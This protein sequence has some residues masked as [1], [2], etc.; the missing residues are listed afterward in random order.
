[1]NEHIS[2]DVNGGVMEIGMNRA[3]K[4]N[5]LTADMYT[6][7]ADA[8]ERA[9]TDGDVGAVLFHGTEDCYTSG[10]D[11]NDF[12]SN[13][14]H[15]SSSPAFRFIRCVATSATPLVAAVTGAAIGVG[16]T[17]LLH[18]DFV[19]ASE[20]AKF[21]MPFV[22]LALVPEAASSLLLPRIAGYQRAANLLLLGE[23]V[24]AR[25]AEACGFVT[26][27]LPSAQVMEKA[28]ETVAKLAAKPP[29]ALRWTRELLKG[30]PADVLNA[31]DRE[32]AYFSQCLDSGEAKEA[33]NAFLEKRSPDFSKA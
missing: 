24:S 16:T 32:I 20:D 21:V 15:D 8:L 29:N 12:L 11:L 18:C 3:D 4:K 13:P 10:N 33:L 2:V 22:N 23:P 9:N 17:M 31:M 26:E 1:M 28:R 19:Y 25:E 5:A 30:D 7:M 6:A 14:P 27:I